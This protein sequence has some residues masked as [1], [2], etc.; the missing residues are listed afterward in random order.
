MRRIDFLW[1]SVLSIV[2]TLIP[3]LLIGN[4]TIGYND[5]YVLAA[6]Q[7]FAI[8]EDVQ[9][10]DYVGIWKKNYSWSNKGTI[11]YSIESNS[12]NAFS[13]DASSGLII[14]SDQ[15]EIN[16]HIVA[17][18]T[19]IELIIRTT[20][21]GFGYDQD[22]VWIYLFFGIGLAAFGRKRLA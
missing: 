4:E 14:I 17:Q 9:N 7:K 11:S 1:K 21:S 15:T 6:K 19:T 12:K 2:L 16:G 22:M 3:I 20:D 18:D 13:I 8:P 5:S 10:G